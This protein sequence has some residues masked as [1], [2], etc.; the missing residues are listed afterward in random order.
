M[1]QKIILLLLVSGL[2]LGVSS[3]F[4]SREYHYVNEKKTWLDAQSYCRVMYSDLATID[5]MD[6]MRMLMSVID[7]C[8]NGS[9]WIGLKRG[10]QPSWGWS[11]GDD[12]LPKY[13]NWTNDGAAQTF[14]CGRISLTWSAYN[15]SQK[16]IGVCYDANPTDGRQY[17]GLTTE[18]TWKEAQTLCR[19]KYTD[20][21]S[22]HSLEEH[23]KVADLM[24]NYSV[25]YMWIG[26][27]SDSWKWS[28]LNNS[29]FRYWADSKPG[30]TDN[31][32]SMALNDF[33]RWYNE[34]CS[35]QHN[36]VCYRDLKQRRQIGR[37]TVSSNSNVNLNDAAV[38]S[39]IL[40]Q[41]EQKLNMGPSVKLSWRW[42]DSKVFELRK[43][44][45][46]AGGGAQKNM[47]KRK[48]ATD[49]L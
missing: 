45:P 3:L 5:N 7:P 41:I 48:R 44:I 28:D 32:V 25:E 21:V 6:E 2:G 16:Y 12:L 29:S 49:E 22:I 40:R 43:K 27:F 11:M 39:T 20:L 10:D 42:K 1:E 33:G 36:F 35:Q 26:L 4:F 8:Y 23:K 47:K 18:K 46:S 34:Q 17:V 31:C 19:N 24:K 15:C 9:V 37:V 13:S 14:P 38:R 30:Q